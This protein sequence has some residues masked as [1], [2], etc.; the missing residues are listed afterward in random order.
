MSETLNKSEILSAMREHQK[1]YSELS[2]QL[3]QITAAEEFESYRA[4]QMSRLEEYKGKFK[5]YVDLSSGETK[6]IDWEE[7]EKLIKT[8]FDNPTYHAGN[9]LGYAL[10]FDSTG[11]CGLGNDYGNGGTFNPM[12]EDEAD[13]R[14]AFEQEKR[15]QEYAAN[16]KGKK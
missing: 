16:V 4:R 5:Y 11:M 6:P 13:G 14:K 3:K 1:A 10:G 12:V 9:L 8:S 2:A 7:V 15:R